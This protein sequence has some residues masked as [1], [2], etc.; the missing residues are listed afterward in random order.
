MARVYVS[1]P[2][3][4]PTRAGEWEQR[5]ADKLPTSM[6]LVVIMDR[7]PA[8]YALR[9]AQKASS[10]EIGDFT[11]PLKS[12]LKNIGPPPQPPE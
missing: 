12:I 7:S 10:G 4:R 8:G 2:G 9:T 5:I 3:E 11:D 1:F 6:A